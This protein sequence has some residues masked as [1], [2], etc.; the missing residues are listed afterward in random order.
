V[1]LEYF[2]GHWQ[3]IDSIEDLTYMVNL[4]SKGHSQ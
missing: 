2:K 3:D 4:Y 1:H